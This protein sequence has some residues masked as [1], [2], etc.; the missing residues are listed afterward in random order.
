MTLPSFARLKVIEFSHAILGPSCGLILADLGMDVIKIEPVEGDPTRTLKGFGVGYFPMFNRN[1]KSLA[2]NLKSAAGRE[3]ALKLAEQAD[4]LL[5]NYAPGTMDRLGLGYEA[6]S[7][8]NPR[9]I[10][11]ALKGY[12]PGPYERRVALDEVVQMQSGIAYMTGPVGQPLRAGVSVVDVLAGAFSALGVLAALRE[13]DRTGCGQLVR[14]GLFESAAYLVGQH[15]VYQPILGEPIPPMPG[16]PRSWAIYQPFETRDGDLVF[17]GVT[18][19]KHWQRFCEV[20]NR[21]DLLADESLATNNQRYLAFD[22]LTADLT[23]MFKR[24]STAEVLAGCERAEIPFAPVA[25]PED[26]LEDPHLLAAGAL[27]NVQ[28]SET[29]RCN[30][31][32]LPLAFSSGRLELRLQPPKVGEHSVEVLQDL[33]YADAQIEQLKRE[34]IVG[35]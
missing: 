24:M 27:W 34:G 2:L 19:D 35:C 17:V 10:Y 31:P 4:V 33:G 25:R 22:R 21:P 9:L 20:F 23:A 11:C 32:T 1:K 6:L 8:R 12:L 26:L 14:G 3:I 30:L 13:R 29:V 15:M 5:E 7:Q 18:S 16:K 28:V